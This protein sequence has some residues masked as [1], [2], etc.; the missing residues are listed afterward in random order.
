MIYHTY[1][2]HK[3]INALSGKCSGRLTPG[4][5][6]AGTEGNLTNLEFKLLNT[7][8]GTVETLVPTVLHHAGTHS[9]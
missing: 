4:G 8:T 2:Y 5:A 7:K 3:F 1:P 6:L 9:R